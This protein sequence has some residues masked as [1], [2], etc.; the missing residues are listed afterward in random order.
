MSYSKNPAPENKQKFKSAVSRNKTVQKA[1]AKAEETRK[2]DCGSAGYIENQAS[3]NK[4]KTGIWEYLN[5]PELPLG[6]NEPLLSGVAILTAIPLTQN[7]ARSKAEA[8]ALQEVIISGV[9]GTGALLEIINNFV[10]IH[11]SSNAQVQNEEEK[12]TTVSSKDEGRED[13]SKTV[14]DI[15]E[16]L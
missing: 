5:I 15:I 11:Q 12:K 3:K 7:N 4:E 2:V 9:I 1:I 13:G 14:D 10:G 16:S 8:T 6:G